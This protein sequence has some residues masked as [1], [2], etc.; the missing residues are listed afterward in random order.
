MWD[1]IT[2]RWLI[3]DTVTITDERVRGYVNKLTRVCQEVGG[4]EHQ[5]TAEIWF[6]ESADGE[7]HG[8]ALLN[9]CV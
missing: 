8:R 1:G 2:R 3:P 6:W 7:M 4:F 9:V 5:D